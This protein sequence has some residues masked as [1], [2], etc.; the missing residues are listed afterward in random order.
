MNYDDYDLSDEP[1]NDAI[2]GACEY[3]NTDLVK[4]LLKDDR[5]HPE[6]SDNFPI[7]IASR[8]GHVDVVK[9]LL[10]DDRVDPSDH[11]DDA[12]RSASTNGHYDVVKILLEDKRVNPAAFNNDAIQ[13]ASRN[14]YVDIVKLLLEDQRVDP[15]ANKNFSI[16]TAVVNNNNEVVKLLIRH[17]RVW[18]VDWEE[19]KNRFTHQII[20]QITDIKRKC[21]ANRCF[22][23]LIYM[24]H[25][26]D[27]LFDMI[28]QSPITFFLYKKVLNHYELKTENDHIAE[29]GRF[30]STLR[31]IK[32][33]NRKKI[34]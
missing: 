6:T 16:R 4:L 20:D 10:S 31:K 25:S 19:I 26:I 8:N 13:D 24:K 29:L 34:I 17:P 33:N 5:I 7:R 32:E 23:Q 27:Y 30:I 12:I 11:D 18:E 15:A 21:E 14:G 22:V 2:K 3:G 9:L 1:E 28:D